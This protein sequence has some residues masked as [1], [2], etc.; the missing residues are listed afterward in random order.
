MYEG[1]GGCGRWGRKRRDLGGGWEREG[2]RDL[3]GEGIGGRDGGEVEG[4]GEDGDGGEGG[5]GGEG[6]RWL[7]GKGGVSVYY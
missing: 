1:G 2:R 6:G 5:E 3:G 7:W 4:E